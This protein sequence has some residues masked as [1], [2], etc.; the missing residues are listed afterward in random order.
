MGVSFA[1]WVL[2][3]VQQL[4]PGNSLLAGVITWSDPGR[5]RG[6]HSSSQRRSFCS[7]PLWM[8][9]ALLTSAVR[10]EKRLA[11]VCAAS[12]MSR[13]IR[14]AAADPVTEKNLCCVCP[15]L[16]LDIMIF[17]NLMEQQRPKIHMLSCRYQDISDNIHLSRILF[18]M[19]RLYNDI[20][21]GHSIS[22]QG[23]LHVRGLLDVEPAPV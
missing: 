19:S 14:D 6:V 18:V 8:T 5:V 7:P 2:S 20:L 23:N 11:S 15:A 21:E 4:R 16:M 1:S 22:L 10:V 17:W 13:M 3:R 12:V 9:A